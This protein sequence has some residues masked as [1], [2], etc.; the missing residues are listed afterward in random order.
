MHLADLHLGAPLSYLGP[1][2]EQRAKD[3]ESAFFRALELAPE[4]NVHAIVIAGDLF[5]TFNPP[6]ELVQRLKVALA[7]AIANG[8]PVILIPGTH[9]SHRYARC[10]YT[11]ESFPG[12]D[13]LLDAGKPVRRELNGHPAYFYGFSGGCSN[14]G[15]SPFRRSPDG[16]LHIALVHGSLS[17]GTHWSQGTR[18]FSLRPEDLR[19]SGF[20]YVALG[21]HHNFKEYRE[22]N[23]LAVYPGTL[24]GIKFGE[25]G[26]RHLIIAEI[27]ER[28][29]TLERIKHNRR[30]L[31]EIRIDLSASD[32]RS[33]EEL[34][35][36]L[37]KFSDLDGIIKVS[38][39]G[40]ADFLPDV[41]A[42]EAR[43]ANS[44]FHLQIEDETTVHES[45]TIRSA[46]NE[47]TVRGI[48]IRKMLER[49]KHGTDD[50]RPATELA[51]RLG[52]E[53]FTR[54]GNENQQTLD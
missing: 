47:N 46:M 40:L 2:A 24:E 52:M 22:D 38:L 23:L 36:R 12:V 5:D 17:D 14:Q 51:L 44:F 39:S 25:N 50:D 20:Q 8:T 9:D 3:L 27:D 4:K 16:G 19:L 45:E 41:Q 10:V 53:Q 29:T 54:V 33:A 48:F 35:T 1:K 43:V 30:T 6:P 34:A 15:A 28:G 32:I 13:I 7:R 11:R 31:S 18:D 26:D 49:I 37:L 21:H 42:I